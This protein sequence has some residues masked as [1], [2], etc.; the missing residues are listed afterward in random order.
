MKDVA[1]IAGVSY[2]TVSHVVNK[3]RFV[4]EWTKKRVLAAIK[5]LDYHPNILARGFKTGKSYTIGLIVSDITNP[6]FP[7]I[8]RGVEAEAFSSNYDIFLSSTNYDHK[9]TSML[10]NRLIEKKVDGAIVAT[11]E[12]DYSLSSYLASKKIPVVLLDWG[13]TDYLI[14]NIKENYTTG[15]EQAINHL[16][17]LG[18]KNIA[19]VAGPENF[20]TATNRKESFISVSN[21]YMDKINKPI[22]IEESLRISGGEAAADKMLGLPSIP[23]A[24]ITSSDLVAIGFIRRIKEK[25]LNVPSDI[26]VIGF[27]DIFLATFIE[28]P[29]TTIGVPRYQIGQLAWKLMNNFI[30]SKNK[31]GKEE[32]IDTTLVIRGTTGKVLNISHK[33]KI[34]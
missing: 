31:K 21:R 25:G 33:N 8:I 27:N 9:K 32:V 11:L 23:T 3:S 10:V 5:E 2:T 26:S 20:K 18:H 1:E 17:E 29:L 34:N 15:M 6:F 28:P 16:M 30:K 7:E 24:V 4:E 19:F 12:A 22:I 13:I 14:S